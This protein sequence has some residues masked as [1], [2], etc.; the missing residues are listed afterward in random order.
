MFRSNASYARCGVTQ[1]KP[2]RPDRACRQPAAAQALGEACVADV[3]AVMSHW[4]EPLPPLCAEL[5]CDKLRRISVAQWGSTLT[6]EIRQVPASSVSNG[7]A[8]SCNCREKF[9]G[10]SNST[11]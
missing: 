6:Q 4:V 2:R 10:A 1:R 3:A 7:A 9:V 8:C 11:D 5:V